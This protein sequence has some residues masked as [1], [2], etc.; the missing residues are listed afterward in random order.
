MRNLRTILAAM[1]CAV[2]MACSSDDREPDAAT[3]GSA[4][5]SAADSTHG[6]VADGA[7]ADGGADTAGADTTGGTADSTM[8]SMTVEATVSLDEKET[9]PADITA[10]TVPFTCADGKVIAATYLSADSGAV[11]LVILRWDGNAYGL[12]RAVSASGARYAALS[13]PTPGDHGLEWWEAK[14]EARLSEFTGT[15]LSDTRPLFT[16][17][18]PGA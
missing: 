13:G 6:D 10:R 18:K 11:S 4:A 12:A 16:G 5:D 7:V 8:D 1:L 2:A 15:D 14:G 17:C 3:I 9:V